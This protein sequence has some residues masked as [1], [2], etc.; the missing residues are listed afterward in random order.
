MWEPVTRKNFSILPKYSSLP[1]SVLD[2]PTWSNLFSII[3]RTK[4]GI[5][6]GSWDPSESIKTKISFLATWADCLIAWPFPL[7]ASKNT[8][9]V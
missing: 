4:F 7:P 3:G 6:L 2:P 8:F 5:S 1:P 9:L